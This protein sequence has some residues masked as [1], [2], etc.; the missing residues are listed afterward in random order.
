MKLSVDAFFKG[1]A[2]EDKEDRVIYDKGT[3]ALYYDADGIGSAKAIKVA[4]LKKGLALTNADFFV[5]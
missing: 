4:T 1:K 5:I 2:A 3:G